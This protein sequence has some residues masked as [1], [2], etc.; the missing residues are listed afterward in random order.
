MIENATVIVNGEHVP[1]RLHEHGQQ[2][3]DWLES[4]YM[5]GTEANLT[6]LKE[7]GGTTLE[8]YKDGQ[9]YEVLEGVVWGLIDCMYDDH[10]IMHL[11]WDGGRDG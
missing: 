11:D 5:E 2:P 10:Y 9:L 4:G 3:P 6:A 8:F 7:K 1:T